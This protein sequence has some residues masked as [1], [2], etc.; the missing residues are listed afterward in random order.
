MSLY[1]QD[2]PL[3]EAKKRLEDA[4]IETGGLKVLGTEVIPLNEYA[5]GRILTKPL[6]AKIS[7]PSYNSAAMDGYAVQARDTVGAKPASPITLTIGMQAKYVDTG[8]PIPDEFNSV[9]PVEEIE[10]LDES[11]SPNR[12]GKLIS[13]IL[14]RSSITPWKNTRTLGE[15]ITVTQLIY[16]GG[17]EL[18]PIDLG[19][20]AS[21]GFS[22]IEV[23]RKPR[24]GILPTGSE[25][26][27]I[28]T[29]PKPG[30]ILEFN[31]LVMAGKIIEW[32]AI[33]TRYP[34]VSDVQDEIL[35]GVV[36][37]ARDND[38]V[39]LNA[40][41]S[42]GSEDYSASVIKKN[43]K[44]L[45]H[46]VAV[47]PGHPVII[48]L[49]NSDGRSVPIIGVPGYP[50]SAA[51]TLDIFVKKII[52]IWLGRVSDA[53]N[54]LMAKLIR[55]VTSPA[56]DD[57]YMRVAIAKIG[58]GFLAIP[59]TRKAGS[60]LSLAQAD[61]ILII[62]SGVQG[63]ESGETA[64]ITLL[65]T[66]K[67]IEKTILCV[68]SHDLA[69][70]ELTK[71]LAKMQRR[72]L[73]VNMGSQGGLIALSR[74]ESHLAGAHLLDPDSGEYNVRYV[75]QYIHNRPVRVVTL[76]HREQGLLIRKN[77]PKNIFN[78]TDLLRK[79][80][81]YINR[82]RGSGTRVL[83]DYYLNKSSIHGKDVSGYEYEEYTHYGVSTA[84]ASG[85]ADC[86][87]G[88][89]SAS[90]PFDLDFIPLFKERYDL[91]I[92]KE[93]A[94]TELLMPLFDILADLEFK[95]LISSMKGYDADLMGRIVW[96]N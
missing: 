87:L 39:L 52:D 12:D 16:I 7:S 44:L 37:A 84:I 15:D 92:A 88:I 91:V 4:L 14:V 53:D 95:K 3:L 31:S 5:V 64:N 68:G 70:D 19:V 56:G 29:N 78:L 2:I 82:Q 66:Q 38:L 25:L 63:I 27:P 10:S 60:L 33:A 40:G 73:S 69:L 67:E 85:R 71:F 22:E 20:I 21:A 30:D 59:L 41:S 11:G 45:V 81:I 49:I 46:G 17:H 62:P 48:G 55:K 43:G 28:G 24:V 90:L 18:R 74:G 47:R 72:F 83:L 86:G 34:I 51:I 76:A 65:R 75:K 94:D 61:G 77:N 80:V 57:E 35:E 32:G 50:V 93:Y 6:H 8:D 13:N 42:A 23:S 26:V 1:L 96:E 89:A 36:N 9:V 58:N 54:S 79:D